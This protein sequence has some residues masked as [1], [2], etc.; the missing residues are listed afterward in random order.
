MTMQTH[1]FQISHL[2]EEILFIYS[3]YMRPEIATSV[4]GGFHFHGKSSHFLDEYV[5]FQ[6]PLNGSNAGIKKIKKNKP[7]APSSSKM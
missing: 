3:Y 1:T 6:K 4:L 2:S 5:R 7:A